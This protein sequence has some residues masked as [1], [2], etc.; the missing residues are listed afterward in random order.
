MNKHIKNG[1][2]FTGGIVIGGTATVCLALH[3]PTL[4]KG[5]ASAVADKIVSMLVGERSAE[6]KP[7][8][9]YQYTHYNDIYKRSYQ[10]EEEIN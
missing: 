7:R 2:I 9:R 4:R 6:K 10:P 8:P 3:S 1:I 5:I